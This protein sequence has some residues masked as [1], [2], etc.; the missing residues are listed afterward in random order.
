MKRIAVSTV[1]LLLVIAPVRA[2]KSAQRFFFKEGDR[3]VFLGD[4]IT[5]QYQYST[6]IELYL[7]TRF[8]TWN[9]QFLNAGISGDTA[10]G[11]AKRFAAHVLAENPTAVTINFGM[12]DGGY[13]NFD[14]G[15]AANFI[16]QTSI[17]VDMAR[18][19][20][21]RVALISPNAVEV[22]NKPTLATY[23]E[24]Q[25]KFY[26][27]LRDLAEKYDIPFVDQ[28]TTTR[29]VLERM[30]ADKS[31][32]KPFP[33]GVHTSEAGGLLMACTILRGLNA[34]AEVSDLVIDTAT[35]QTTAS[36]CKAEN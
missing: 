25:R 12:N 11:G 3:V 24:T 10:T 1:F 19:S 21:I 23:L 31:K 27:G 17:M 9:M 28:Y 18:K 29:Q 8:P 16:K 4:S 6:Y 5:E 13:G 22:R 32:V 7:T 15:A 2:Q 34:P 35:K 33:D 30:A 36:N 14:V 20:R 26:A